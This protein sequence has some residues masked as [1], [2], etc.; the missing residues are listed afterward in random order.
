MSQA[1]SLGVLL[2]TRNSAERL[3]DHLAAMASWIDLADQVVVVD[4]DS[5]DGT[6]EM[7][8]RGMNH[9]QV[10]YV[11]HPPGLYAS[12]NAG[13]R[14]LATCYAYISTVGE[15][16]TRAGLQQLL[17]TARSFEVDVVLSRPIFTRS[18]GE[19]VEV[20]SPIDDIVHTLRI[21]SPRRLHTLEAMVFASVHAGNA[22]TGSCASDLFRTA[23]LKQFPFPTEY[24]T[25]GDGIWCVQH[26]AQVTWAVVPDRFSTFL[27]HPTTLSQAE[28][29][30]RPEA[31]R[32]DAVLEAA[33]STWLAEGVVRDADLQR[34][35]WRTLQS[36]LIAYLNAKEQFDGHRKSA[37]PWILN[38]RAWQT[39]RRRQER[40]KQLLGAKEAALASL[41]GHSSVSAGTFAGSK[42]A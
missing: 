25:A 35:H 26:A 1:A 39:R 33:V 12:W 18:T 37:L 28:N 15:T 16:I 21:S 30:R 36:A 11:S 5:S 10:Q 23:T 13:L 34:I 9:P 8:R 4:S 17:E 2:P 14:A 7:I 6:L 29:R 27:L 20:H 3:P 19:P 40:R 41:A 24:G 22:L 38:P 31:Q 42:P 32:P